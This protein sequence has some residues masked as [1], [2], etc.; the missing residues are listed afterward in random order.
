MES[1]KGSRMTFRTYAGLELKHEYALDEYLHLVK[2]FSELHN[3]DFPNP[4]KTQVI[5]P[6]PGMFPFVFGLYKDGY[7]KNPW[8][9]MQYGGH[10]DAQTLNME[11]QKRYLQ[12]ERDFSFAFDGPSQDGYD[13]DHPL[14]RVFV[15]RNGVAVNTVEDMHA[16]F[17]EIPMDTLHVSFTINPT[18]PILLAYFLT[19]LEE[20]GGNVSDAKITIQNDI[21]KEYEFRGKFIFH[22]RPSVK[23]A[24]DGMEYL[25]LQGIRGSRGVS[26]SAYHMGETLLDAVDQDTLTL[27]NG[28]AY[29]DE[30][31]SRGNISFERFGRN[32]SFF[33]NLEEE[34]DTVAKINVLRWK[35]AEL[36][37]EKYHPS[38]PK[39]LFVKLHT[40]CAGVRA[41]RNVVVSQSRAADQLRTAILS[42]VQSVH[43]IPGSEYW[44]IPTGKD[45]E[46][47]R[48]IH[49]Y[50]A[51]ETF[52]PQQVSPM[53]YSPILLDATKQLKEKVDGRLEELI[54]GQ[55][56]TV[57]DAVGLIVSK[58][59]YEIK[60][61]SVERYLAGVREGVIVR[62]G[63]HPE[64]PQQWEEYVWSSKAQEQQLMRLQQ[65]RERRD[66]KKV[67]SVL[68]SINTLAIQY[69]EAREKSQVE[70]FMPLFMGAAKY[71]VSV[72]EICNTLR[73]AW[74][75]YPF[76]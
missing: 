39:A 12:G 40:H 43:L 36:M 20:Q 5:F 42:N 76:S 17:H 13:S 69:R 61:N 35:W 49:E 73:N 47:V 11:L 58:R 55:F 52:L 53:R 16:L 19:A 27:I 59:I 57:E 37:Q 74:G 15:G 18:A 44:G 14:A 32:V 34:I 63:D 23:L 56:A 50:Y 22:P 4:K 41:T 8:R 64:F 48:G 7:L 9:R 29:V 46:D 33:T 45:A 1:R 72:G 10:S 30:V 75:E 68:S 70:N 51:K 31:A 2:Y 54:H 38:D 60:R 66:P 25:A 3:P 65:T 71:R 28:Q 62:S 21:L 67:S 26:V 6:Q 24:G